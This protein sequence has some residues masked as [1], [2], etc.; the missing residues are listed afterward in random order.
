MAERPKVFEFV[1]RGVAKELAAT[2]RGSINRLQK[3]SFVAALTRAKAKKQEPKQNLNQ[4]GDHLQGQQ[5][6]VLWMSS[7]LAF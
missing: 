6:K 1:S 7:G 4:E 3:K 5:S 2:A